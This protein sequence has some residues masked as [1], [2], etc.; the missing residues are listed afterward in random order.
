MHFWIL[1]L[2]LVACPAPETKTTDDTALGDTALGDTQGADTQG[3]DTQGA[4]T[5]DSGTAP[6]EY[7]CPEEMSLVL[8]ADSSLPAFCIDTYEGRATGEPG[9][10]DQFFGVET[11]S[12]GEIVS[13][14]GVEPTALSFSQAVVLCEQ[15]PMLDHKGETVGTKRLATF[16]EWQDSGDGVLGEGGLR[17]PYGDEQ[18]DTACHVPTSTGE[19]TVDSVQLTGSA[20]NCVS[21][22]GVHDQIGNYWEWADSG[23]TAD[24]DTWFEHVEEEAGLLV[25]QN[26]EGA[27]LYPG[28]WPKDSEGFL[29][30]I[31]GV[32][33]NMISVQSDGRMTVAEQNLPPEDENTGSSPAGYFSYGLEFEYKGEGVT[34]LGRAL[35]VV[36][37][38][39]TGEGYG[40]L[41]V[42]SEIDGVQVGYKLGGAWYTGGGTSL[43]PDE[44]RDA[45]Q[46]PHDFL[47]SI[48]A[49]CTADALTR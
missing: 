13:E 38:I 22:F 48:A 27:V 32:E 20:E 28:V 25:S 10:I 45:L 42:R 5:A 2:G 24:I 34:T 18:S 35:P 46:H 36:L 3:V 40:V 47:G 44:P 23:L 9:D 14:V 37:D 39:K 49:R 7:Y 21:P 29:L 30:T 41:Y 11:P 33:P 12:T 26:K 15:T 17:Y 16:Q 43:Q 6:V 8:D 19:T 4:D 1:A 31:A